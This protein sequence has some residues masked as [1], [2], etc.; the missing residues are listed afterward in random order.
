M[1]LSRTFRVIAFL[2]AIGALLPGVALAATQT[3]VVKNLSFGAQPTTIN[4]G[5]S[6][7]WT[8]QDP[9]AHTVTANNAAFDKPLP[10]NGTVTIA[11]TAAGSYAYHCSI[12]PF[13]TGTIVVAGPTPAPS[14]PRPTP[15]PT[16]PPTVPPT[17]PP[18]ASPSPAPTPSPSPSPTPSPTPT[19]APSATGTPIAVPST[20]ALASPTVGPGPDLGSGPGPVIAGGAV[21][22]ALLLGGTALYLYRRR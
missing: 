9:V 19:P 8:N 7:T 16:A 22:L 20:V 12:H 2:I 17:A 11:F 14:T 21:I 1:R 6:V 4:V 18:T 13:M 10:A 5:D 3:V 15:P